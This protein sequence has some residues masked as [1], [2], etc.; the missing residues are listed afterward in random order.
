[1]TPSCPNELLARRTVYLPVLRKSQN[2]GVDI[3]NL[4]DFPDVNQVN[5]AR[6]VTTIPT[7]ALYLNNSPFFQQQSKLL[8]SRMLEEAVTEAARVDWLMQ[9]TLGRS[10]QPERF[11]PKR[12]N[13]FIPSQ[14][15]WLKKARLLANAMR[16][17]WDRYCHALLA[18]NEFLYLR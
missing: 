11:K 2:R 8:A 6:S 14:R 5:G 16:E 4:F 13:F 12:K 3:L 9:R 17:A 10:A 7:Q 18:S 15:S 1:M